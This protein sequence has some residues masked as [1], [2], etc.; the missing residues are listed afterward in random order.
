MNTV[1]IYWSGNS[2]H[3]RVHL[4]P[5][6]WGLARTIVHPETARRLRTDTVRNLEALAQAGAGEENHTRAKLQRVVGPKA[7]LLPCRMCALERVMDATLKDAP[8][9]GTFVTFSAMPSHVSDAHRYVDLDLTDTAADRL[10]RIAKRA[11]LKTT[12]SR[13]GTVAYGIVRPEAVS[14]ISA[15]LR[16][17]PPAQRAYSGQEVSIVWSLVDDS[18]GGGA[19]LGDF[20]PWEVATHI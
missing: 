7:G 11:G 6:C 4:D 3:A 9:S 2:P 10:E 13:I 20:D 15:N 17:L 8:D 16:T 19:P 1:D 12:Q 5:R 18:F 14:V